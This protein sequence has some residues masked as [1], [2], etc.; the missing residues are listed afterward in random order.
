[1][2]PI[3]MVLTIDIPPDGGPL[4][5]TV[6]EGQF[7]TSRAEAQTLAEIGVVLDRFHRAVANAAINAAIAGG[8]RK[9]VA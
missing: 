5:F 9:R 4:A 6:V 7:Q 8:A 1:M 3:R 2:D